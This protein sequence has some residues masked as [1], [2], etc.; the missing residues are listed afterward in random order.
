MAQNA[1]ESS[2][3]I[4]TAQPLRYVQ[5]VTL[6]EPLPLQSDGILAG[7]TVAFET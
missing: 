7:V 4:R 3:S 6:D 2:D 1:F 5:S